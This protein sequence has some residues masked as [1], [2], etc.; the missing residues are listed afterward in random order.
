MTVRQFGAQRETIPQTNT[1]I[2][3]VSE[4]T[5]SEPLVFH[6]PGGGEASRLVDHE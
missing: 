4:V 5:L 1:L 2:S 3:A 6:A